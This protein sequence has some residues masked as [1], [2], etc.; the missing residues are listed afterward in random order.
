MDAII[1]VSLW[2]SIPTYTL[3]F[4]FFMEPSAPK[5]HRLPSHTST[6]IISR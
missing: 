3:V 2:T 5:E 1:A 6:S 4:S